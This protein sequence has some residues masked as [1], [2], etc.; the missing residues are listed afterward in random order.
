MNFDL[1]QQ[2]QRS[3]SEDRGDQVSCVFAASAHHLIRCASVD[4]TSSKM[5][6]SVPPRS[7]A[8]IGANT[9]SAGAHMQEDAGR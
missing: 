2:F 1:C 6:V 7:R 8:D 5:E 3:T 4:F 9:Y